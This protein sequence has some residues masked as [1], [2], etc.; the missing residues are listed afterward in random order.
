[1]KT[2]CGQQDTS[3]TVTS[4]AAFQKLLGDLHAS[5]GAQAAAVDRDD[6]FKIPNIMV[7]AGDA[8][9]FVKP[10]RRRFWLSRTA[11]TDADHIVQSVQAA[12][13]KKTY[14]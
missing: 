10:L 9:Y 12:A 7:L 8:F 4:A 2:G 1:M 11:L 3:Y 5:I 14:S 6:L 13:W